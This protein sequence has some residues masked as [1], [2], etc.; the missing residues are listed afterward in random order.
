MNQSEKTGKSR[1]KEASDPLSF[2]G[3]PMRALPLADDFLALAGEVAALIDGHARQ[4]RE[5]EKTR[6]D[7]RLKLRRSFA[8]VTQLIYHLDQALGD[9]QQALK[10]AGLDK[11]HKRLRIVKDQLKDHLAREG[12]V[13]RD[14]IGEPFSGALTE[15]VDVDGWR[16]SAE[17]ARET[18]I[19]T[20][21]PM[22]VY[23]E[24]VILGG[25]VVIGA[26]EE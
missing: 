2:D 21:E 13:W 19:E 11:P 1:G 14:P 23:G 16:H 8:R 26:P 20:R 18:V 17:Y 7:E 3:H 24:E 6:D 5:L 4:V 12:Y 15:L 9:S 10:D 22:I 25:A